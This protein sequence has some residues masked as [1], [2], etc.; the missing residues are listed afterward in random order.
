MTDED[1]WVRTAFRAGNEYALAELDA[2]RKLDVLRGSGSLLD[3]VRLMIKH[4]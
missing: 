3:L 1:E 2:D 4:G